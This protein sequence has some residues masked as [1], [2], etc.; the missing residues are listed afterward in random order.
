MIG[1]SHVGTE[2]IQ[3]RFFK[4]LADCTH[5]R[6]RDLLFSDLRL[7]HPRASQERVGPLPLC[8]R[9]FGLAPSGVRLFR[10]SFQVVL[11][12]STGAPFPPREASPFPVTSAF[13]RTCGT[14]RR[15]DFCWAI[16]SSFFRPPSFR[17]HRHG[18]QQISRV[19]HTDFATIPSP[20]RLHLRRESGFAAAR[21]LTQM[22][23]PYGASLSFD[24]VAHLRLPPDIPSRAHRGFATGK[25]LVLQIDALVTSVSGSP[26]QGPGFG[27]APPVCGSCR[28]HSRSSSRSRLPRQGIASCSSSISTKAACGPFSRRARDA[29][30]PPLVQSGTGTAFL[31]S[32]SASC[33]PRRHHAA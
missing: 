14:S 3:K 16:V 23:T 24:T 17:T 32:T 29:R 4:I 31:P 18:A 6:G 2:A 30:D 11:A 27:L 33:A 12:S 19:R 20:L 13:R 21:R 8:R 9:T 28:S 5:Q 7:R 10:S 1:R 22:R 15:S 25:D 26:R